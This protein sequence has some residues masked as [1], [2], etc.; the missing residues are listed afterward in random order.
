MGGLRFLKAVPGRI[1]PGPRQGT[2]RGEL[3]ET[4]RKKEKSPGTKSASTAKEFSEKGP[5][6]AAPPSWNVLSAGCGIRRRDFK[7]KFRPADAGFPEVRGSA[8][9]FFFFFKAPPFPLSG[10]DHAGW[11]PGGGMGKIPA[12]KERGLRRGRPCGRDNKVGQFFLRRRRHGQA[13]GQKKIV[14]RPAHGDCRP[15][16]PSLTRLTA[17]NTPRRSAGKWCAKGRR[18]RERKGAR[19]SRA[20]FR[21]NYHYAGGN[22][23]HGRS[24]AHHGAATRG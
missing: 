2:G 21:T 4:P 24:A 8:R 13:K 1:R 17:G 10:G 5:R 6:A 12:E 15:T 18:L 16:P 19:P 20:P 23:K 7:R 22:I 11:G 9:G 3:S 14:H